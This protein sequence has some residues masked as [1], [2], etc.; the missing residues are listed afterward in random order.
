MFFVGMKGDIE[1]KDNGCQKSSKM[2]SP[3]HHIPLSQK[4]SKS[5]ILTGY[6]KE[7]KCC[8]I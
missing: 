6:S 8:S 7:K 4:T 2:N 1:D 5:E 3:T